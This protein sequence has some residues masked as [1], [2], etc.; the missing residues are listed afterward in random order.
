MGNNNE[1]TYFSEVHASM[2]SHLFGA[3]VSIDDSEDVRSLIELTAA[4]PLNFE[5]RISLGD[6]LCMQLRYLEAVNQFSAAIALS[7][8]SFAG[9]YKR[10]QRYLCL[11]QFHK[12]L[13]DYRICDEAE[14]DRFDLKYKIGLLWYCLEE[15]RTA[16]EYFNTAEQICPNAEMLVAVVCWRHLARIRTGKTSDYQAER[17]L[18]KIYPGLDTGHHAAYNTAAELFQEEINLEEAAQILEKTDNDM[19]YVTI[20]YAVYHLI[21]S[22]SEKDRARRL[23]KELL[24]RSYYWPSFTYTAALNDYRRMP[25]NESQNNYYE[26]TV[27]TKI[28]E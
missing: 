7:P 20:L 3:P 26:Y 8:K 10:A 4:D 19:D 22:K 23:L 28:L 21:L 27:R 6:A 24:K 5:L 2:E 13:A 9:Y 1:H 12:A 14:P 18:F 17:D 25:D 16:I 11:Q 15:Y